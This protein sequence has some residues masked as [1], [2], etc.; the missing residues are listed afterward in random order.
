MKGL[1]MNT[2]PNAIG[3]GPT[4]WP[5][6]AEEQYATAIKFKCPFCGVEPDV[7]CNGII[8]P[9]YPHTDRLGVAMMEQ[10]WTE[11]Q[12]AALYEF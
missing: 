9:Q 6:T 1:S 5:K 12:I 2:E 8:F 4:P 3:N 10:G 11:Q 7:R